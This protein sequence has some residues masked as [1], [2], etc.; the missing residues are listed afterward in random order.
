[1]TLTGWPLSSE[2][3][4]ISLSGIVFSLTPRLGA[5]IRTFLR[6]QVEHQL[7]FVFAL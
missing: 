7:F 1:M 3:Y 6:P 2:M 4:W 5:Y